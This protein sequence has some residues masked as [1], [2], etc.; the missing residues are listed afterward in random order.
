[1]NL[2]ST[3]LGLASVG[4]SS[5]TEALLLQIGSRTNLF[6]V[7]P[8]VPEMISDSLTHVRVP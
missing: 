5:L 3:K 1:M 7:L 8:T 2:Y 6:N 4:G